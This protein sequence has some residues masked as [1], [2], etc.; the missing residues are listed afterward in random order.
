MLVPVIVV[1]AILSAVIPVLDGRSDETL[2]ASAE[3]VKASLPEALRPKFDQALLIVLT[4]APDA[5]KAE[6]PAEAVRIA[7]ASLHGKT[8]EEVIRS[9]EAMVQRI[10]DDEAQR[11]SKVTSR[12]LPAGT[13]VQANTFACE[14]LLSTSIAPA[15]IR[16][17]QAYRISETSLLKPEAEPRGSPLFRLGGR[18]SHSDR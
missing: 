5:S 10:L 16:D 11:Q 4:A 17:S 7:R 8:A 12:A 9:A 13:P 1:G 3:K 18:A 15:R 14:A 2:Q 6:D